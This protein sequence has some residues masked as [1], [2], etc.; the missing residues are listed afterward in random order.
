MSDAWSHG[1]CFLRD[2][3]SVATTES[4]AYVLT[5]RGEDLL[6]SIDSLPDDPEP[7]VKTAPCTKCNGSG[8]QPL[9]VSMETCSR[10]KG[11]KVE[12]VALDKSK[13]RRCWRGHVNEHDR[14]IINVPGCAICEIGEKILV[15]GFDEDDTRY[16]CI[17]AEIVQR[18]PYSS[19]VRVQRLPS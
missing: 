19:K 4:D 9:F 11:D 17:I 6:A 15:R 10:C 16:T 14:T 18:E 7:D 13:P 1:P 3:P 12:P 8:K 5:P 2:R